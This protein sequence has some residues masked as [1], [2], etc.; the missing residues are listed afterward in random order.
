MANDNKNVEL[1]IRAKN[2]TEE[3]FKKVSAALKA[4]EEQSTQTTSKGK[5]SWTSWFATIAGGVAVGNLL[6]SAFKTVGG[7]LASIPGQL[8]ELSRRGSDV[9]DVRASFESLAGGVNMA[10]ETLQQLRA[11][12]GRAVSD[13]ELM[14]SSNDLLRKGVEM[15]GA[16]FATL[17]KGARI[18]ADQVG[19]DAKGNFDRFLSAIGRGNERELRDLGIN[20]AT[21]E[22]AVEAHARAL[23][24]ETSAL[25][26]AQRQQA[27]KNAALAE[28]NRLLRENGEPQ[29]DFNDN[30]DA[31]AALLENW[32]DRLG[33]AIATSPH[34]N[35]ALGRIAEGLQAAFGDD[36]QAQ[37][38]TL[39]KLVGHL[40]IASVEAAQVVVRGAQ[41]MANAY[42]KTRD[43]I[44]S[45][46]EWNNRRQ[47]AAAE[48]GLQKWQAL[49]EKG[50]ELAQ[51]NV[52]VY[53]EWL[54]ELR[55]GS[56][57]LA[58]IGKDA[59]DTEAK[60]NNMLAGAKGALVKLSKDLD[61]IL[62]SAPKAGGAVGSLGGRAGSAGDAIGGANKFLDDFRKKLKEMT[63]AANTAAA[64]NALEV[65][66]HKN[67]SALAGLAAD[68]AAAGTALSGNLLKGLIANMVRAGDAHAG[69]LAAAI[70][71][72][73]EEEHRAG[74]GRMNEQ[75]L[76]GLSIRDQAERDF[77]ATRRAR[78][79]AAHTIQLLEIGEERD[80]RIRALERTG[81]ATDENLSAVE[82]AYQEKMAAARQAHNDELERMKA[83]LN[84]WGN[85]A[86][87]WAKSFPELLVQG[88][89]GGGGMSGALKAIGATAG[90]DIFS[91]LFTGKDGKGGLAQ[92]LGGGKLGEMIGGLAG[93]LGSLVGSLGGSLLGKIFGFGNKEKKENQEATKQ[94]GELRDELVATYGSMDN[95]RMLG[96]LTGTDITA[97]FGHQGK[98][99]L[100][101]FKRDMDKFE[102]EVGRFQASFN[103]QL[104]GIL[105]QAEGVGFRLPDTLNPYIAKFKEL[106]L[107]TDENQRLLAGIGESTVIDHRKMEEAATLLGVRFE[108]LGGA[109]Q[110]A[111]IGETAAQYLE[112]LDLLKRGGAD[113]GA[114][115]ADSSGKISE[116]V[117]Q[118]MRS[119]VPLAENW[120]GYVEELIRT[121]QLLDANGEKIT[122]INTLSFGDPIKIGLERI[123]DLLERLLKGLGIDLPNALADIPREIDFQ[124]NVHTNRTESGGPSRGG[125]WEGGDVDMPGADAGGLFTKPTLRVFAERQPEVAG[126]PNAIVDALTRAMKDAGWGSAAG[127]DGQIV[128]ENVTLVMKDGRVI[129]EAAGPHLPQWVKRNVRGTRG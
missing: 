94:V 113:M 57:A 129:A 39:S 35:L 100:E 127:G 11:G 23:G 69:E 68:A 33:E 51:D 96:K 117:Q 21:V 103:D 48:E 38:A 28:A 37:V 90:K 3:A 66:A 50:D 83:A 1:Q 63:E 72:R 106:G 107:I 98:K 118:S 20:M 79:M 115:L 42:Y 95:L 62:A 119:G 61:G 15:T 112:A 17:A 22:R 58:V 99:G 10:R 104:G 75:F 120:R 124:V 8:L 52:R 87:S 123:G 55:L 81:H 122:D 18:L 126:S 82:R 41:M 53:Q 40:A 86:K 108:S 46:F 24:V 30:L 78:T 6:A 44:Q 29:N 125:V 67:A 54:A 36:Q 7:I 92:L 88:L 59:E 109:F 9:A 110:R 77:L 114:V 25:T 76:E 56:V 13:V 97:A 34:L 2:L 74:I 121:G 47:I 102:K 80:A 73:Q 85:M 12:F 101:Q 45:V 32:K 14:K 16:E 19:G 128:I 84:T 26:V 93:P 65:W 49:A 70:M 64:N 105:R 116:F 31:G 5:T 111:K 71:K 89:T 43:V 27:L 4:L 60:F 91:N